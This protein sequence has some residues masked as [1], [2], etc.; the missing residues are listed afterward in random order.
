LKIRMNRD[1]DTYEETVLFGLT[2]KQFFFSVTALVVGVGLYLLCLPYLGS[3]FACY[4]TALVVAPLALTGFYRLHDMSFW[5]VV[6][7][8]V[9]SFLAKPLLYQTESGKKEKERKKKRKKWKGFLGSRFKLYKKADE[10]LFES[11]KRV[12][13]TIE[14]KRIAKNGIFE[15]Q[16]GLYSKG[17]LFTDINYAMLADEEKAVVLERYCQLLNA[18]DIRHKITILNRRQREKDKERL[19]LRKCGDGF[20]DMRDAYNE[21]LMESIEKGRKG[22][23]Q[24]RLITI[25]V[26]RKSYE[27]AKSYF[28]DTEAA[29]R[30]FLE[31]LGSSMIPLDAKERLELIY[32]LYHTE[33]DVE[34]MFDFE[35]CVKER[36][37]YVNDLSNNMADYRNDLID[38]DGHFAKAYYLKQYPFF[39]PDS[40]LNSVVNMPVRLLFSMDISPIQ[41]DVSLKTLQNKYMG[42]E[43]DILRQQ[44]KRNKNHDFSTDISYNKR[45][46]KE[47]LE[48]TMDDVLENDENVFYVGATIVLFAD[49]K[50][51]LLQA[52]KN[53]DIIAKSNM[54]QICAHYLKQREAFVTA[55]PLGVRLTSTMRTMLSQSATCLAPFHTQELYLP[56]GIHYGVNQ[57]SKNLIQGNR[58]KLLNGNGMVFAVTGAGKS[59]FT[60]YEIGQVLLQ[61]KDSVIIIDPH[62]EYAALTNLYQGT[63]VNVSNESGVC[64]NPL[65]VPDEIEDMRAFLTEKGE[66]MHAFCEQCMEHNM[67]YRKKSLI[68]RVLQKLYDSYFAGERKVSPCLSDFQRLMKK[69]PE[70]EAKDVSLAL[71]RYTD[72]IFHLFDGQTNVNMDDRFLVYGI[73]ELGAEL[74]PLAML[75]MLAFI[76]EKIMENHKKGIA[77]WLYIDEFHRTRRSAC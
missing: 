57:I 75:L 28:N 51:E 52:E 2:A 7:R 22:L 25:I 10:P 24:L 55:L 29:L 48:E 30:T 6:T 70:E 16:D 21:V 43:N 5:E 62:N 11:P 34:F 26:E 74:S 46:E 14:I 8:Y 69:Q 4:V 35:T 67:D 23:T 3:V 27:D 73:R 31:R 17:Y 66:L 20:D 1:I 45:K 54:I 37:D 63:F 76:E 38:L 53:L 13:D 60:K 19:L 32:D 36:R 33:D 61:S 44:Q 59:F 12:Q 47:E 72:G 49:S 56:D 42:I 77:T 64:L 40:F 41:R 68:D 65:F 50:E 71:E 9:R 18:L 15:L 39:V 58:K